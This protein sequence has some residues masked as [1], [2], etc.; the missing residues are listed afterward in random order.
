METTEQ[1]QLI[2]SYCPIELLTMADYNP[3]VMSKQD[4]ES[5]RKSIERFGFVDPI[6]VNTFP[7]RENVIVGGHQRYEMAKLM[8]I[9]QVP[10]V[11]VYLEIEKEKE[12]NVFLNKAVGSWDYDK[13]ANYFDLDML[14]DVGFTKADLSH[15]MT[16]P[17]AEDGFDAGEEYEKITTPKAKRGDIYELGRH[18]IMCGD[19]TNAED[20]A[21]LMNGK[22]ADMIFTDPP[23]G[24]N[25]TYAKYEAIHKERKKKFIDK[26]KIFNDDKDELGQYQFILDS[27][28]LAYAHTAEAAP[29]YVCYATKQEIAFQTAFRDAGWHFSQVIIWLKERIILAM[30]QDYHRCYE[31][32][33]FGWKQGNKHYRDKHDSKE[34]ELWD[35]DRMTFEERLDLW[36]IARDKSNDYIHPTQKPIRL[37]ERALKKSS[38]VD[39][40]LYEPFLGSASTLIACEQ[41]G[42]SCYGMELDPK[43]VDVE[44]QRWEAL[45]KQKAKKIA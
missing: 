9:K 1:K 44:I 30:G 37:I 10:V 11:T 45:T 4:S 28:T 15:A 25:Y 5:L 21:A 14:L 3:R 29:I 8:G 6:I 19:S 20:V 42:R 23:Y 39:D 34:K 22:K 26:G 41:A 12:L 18:R 43:Y 27:L 36:Y 13:L 33:L 16:K 40:L 35:L 17:L 32:I 38:K 2:I 7:G 24:V 31:P